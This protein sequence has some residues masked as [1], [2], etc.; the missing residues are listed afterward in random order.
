[1]DKLKSK[2]NEV[3]GK[4]EKNDILVIKIL[5]LVVKT[6]ID[7]KLKK[8]GRRERE[9]KREGERDSHKDRHIRKQTEG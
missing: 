5:S 4:R 9:G 7:R 1:M 2:V 3:G 8:Y 6:D